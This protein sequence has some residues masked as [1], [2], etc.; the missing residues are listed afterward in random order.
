MRQMKEINLNLELSV[1]KY[2]TLVSNTVYLLRRI[3][4]RIVQSLS[5]KSFQSNRG[6]K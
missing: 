5:L 6:R 1:I 2:I 3:N 4:I